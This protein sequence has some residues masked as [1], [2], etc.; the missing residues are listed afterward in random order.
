[1]KNIFKK[2]YGKRLNLFGISL[3]YLNDF[4]EYSLD[5]KLYR[6]LGLL[7]PPKDLKTSEKFLNSLI[8]RSDKKKGFWW[9]IYL[10][11]ERKVIGSIGTHNIDFERKSLEISYA[12]SP[13]HWKNGFFSET[14]QMIIKRFIIENKFNRIFAVTDIDN[15]DSINSLKKN[16]FIQEGVLRDFS[17]Y[18]RNKFKDAVIL[19]FCRKHDLKNFNKNLKKFF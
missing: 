4:H 13:S 2:I 3:K 5:K 14:I 9:F 6:H 11:S 12:L 15:Q 18:E 16:F 10:K 19:S 1:M 17:V 7:K 8:L